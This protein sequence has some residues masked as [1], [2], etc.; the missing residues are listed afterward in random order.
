MTEQ[1]GTPRTDLG[2]E[3]DPERDPE[4][5]PERNRGTP[6][7]AAP[8]WW[9]RRLEAI[10]QLADWARGGPAPDWPLEIFLEI[11]N[12]CDLKCAMCPTFSGLS[13]SRLFSIK[14]QERGFLAVEQVLA[15]LEPMLER[16]LILHCFGYGEPTLHP[17][18]GE[19]LERLRPYRL[20]VDFFTNGMHLDQDFCEL[21]VA[22]HVAAVTVSFSGADRLSYEAV[23]QGGRFDTVLAGLDRLR[24]TKAAAKSLY[25]RVEINSLGFEHQVAKLPEFVELMAA[26]G[27]EVIHLKALQTFEVTQELL[28]HRSVPRPWIEGPLL[29]RAMERARELGLHLS[30]DQYWDTRVTDDAAWQ[31]ARGDT[32]GTLPLQELAACAE[33]KTPGRPAPGQ[34]SQPQRDAFSLSGADLQQAMDFAPYQGETPFYCFEPFKTLYVRRSGNIKPCCFA[35]DAGPTLGSLA[36][37]TAAAI[38]QGAPWRALRQGL[39]AQRYPMK[40]C[41][42]CLHHGYGPRRHDLPNQLAAYSRWLAHAFG[43]QLERELDQ[44][45]PTQQLSNTEIVHRARAEL[46]YI[47]WLN[48]IRRLIPFGVPQ[49][50]LQGHLDG[51]RDGWLH[52]W[53]RAPEKPDLRL[54]VALLCDGQPWQRQRADAE[55]EDLREAG[56]GDGNYGFAVPLADCPP[57]ATLE[58]YLADTDWLLGRV[59]LPPLP[60]S[61]QRAPTQPSEQPPAEE[62]ANLDAIGQLHAQQTPAPAPDRAPA[63]A[64][65]NPAAI[66][67][68]EFPLRYDPGIHETEILR[69]FAQFADSRPPPLA[70]D[71]DLTG[72]PLLIIVF[73]NRS[74]SNLLA[75]ALAAT[76]LV[77]NAGECFNFSAVQDHCTRSGILDLSGYLHHLTTTAATAGRFLAI[78]LS[79]DQLYF[80]TKV[81]VIPHYWRQPRF[82]WSLREDLLAQALSAIVAERTHCWTEAYPPATL[83]TLLAAITPGELAARVQQISH[84]IS[85]LQSYFALHDITPTLIE[86]QDLAQ[87][88]EAEAQRALK[89]QNL[90]PPNRPWQFDPNQIQVRKQRTPAMEARLEQLRHQLRL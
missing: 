9:P 48:E 15:K 3:R 22:N 12:L 31:A 55:R 86:Y 6:P 21:L 26:H 35:D 88:P 80:L 67:T 7:A 16:A 34:A 64:I 19:L 59:Q 49:S 25:P 70:P 73:G 45:L 54:R 87:A 30:C 24:A 68:A 72:Q 44:A 63:P 43:L 77:Y 53:L 60:V 32:N 78:K 1:S 75:Q 50:Q 4:R 18:F 36:E 38:W 85:Q 41:G 83:N 71:P 47:P 17:G 66:T 61:E 46:D 28:G 5:N 79:W 20:Q 69:F 82:L 10:S 39:L 62:A 52:G 11:S 51:I 81:G 42:A 33:A 74:G 58:V 84:G 37:H 57:G 29:E 65:A 76:G 40:L 8:P 13:P 90:I 89:E 27:A 2:P 14:E 56:I 23:Y